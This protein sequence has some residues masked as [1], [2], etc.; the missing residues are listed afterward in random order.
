[1]LKGLEY[2][3]GE[4]KIHR[5]IKAANVLLSRTGE[6][7]H[8]PRTPHAARSTPCATL[9]NPVQLVLL[10]RAHAHTRTRTRTRTRALTRRL[11]RGRSR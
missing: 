8:A 10:T 4:A 1:M 5:D 6:V 3:H 9:C 2:L 11:P 7:P